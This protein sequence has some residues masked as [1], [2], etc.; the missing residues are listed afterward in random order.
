MQFGAVPLDQ[1]LGAILAHS[2]R[3][4]PAAGEGIL[5]KGRVLQEA[6]LARLAAMGL[7]VVMRDRVFLVF[8]GVYC[9]AHYFA[10]NSRDE[11]ANYPTGAVVEVKGSADVRAADEA[12]NEI[13]AAVSAGAWRS[14]L[15]TV[16]MP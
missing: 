9:M 3:D 15:T 11:L 5:R 1:A 12:F 14:A 8:D 10:L 16:S 4:D 6:D 7:D 13:S 2:L